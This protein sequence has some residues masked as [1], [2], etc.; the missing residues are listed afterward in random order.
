MNH[1]RY[2]LEYDNKKWEEFVAEPVNTLQLFITNKCNLRC[3]GCFYSHKLGKGE[4]SIEEYKKHVFDNSKTIKK[5]IILGGEP[6]LHPNLEEMIQFNN[7]QDLRTTIYTN[8]HNL[9]RLE[10]ADLSKT[11]IRIGV[12]GSFNSEK[13]LYKIPSPNIPV[14]VVYM[15]RKDNI[16]EL[17]EAA[18]MAESRFDCKAFYI[19]SIRDITITQD[20]WK[21]TPETIPLKE[22]YQ[23]VQ[24][25]VNEYEGGISSLHIARRGVIETKK[26]SNHI[27]KCRF[28]NIFPDGEK[29]IC[30]FDISR[31]LVASEISFGKN[32]CNKGGCVL[33]KIVLERK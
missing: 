12:Y 1:E 9:K 19:S 32:Y 22:Y 6:T 17:N 3:K 27:N 31:K 26:Q 24:K 33:T 5:V 23:L 21:D 11:Q 30:P 7:S 18:T 10:N 4:M 14:T 25:F 8:G 16:T 2:L 13:P 20:Y 28:G 15:L 29:I